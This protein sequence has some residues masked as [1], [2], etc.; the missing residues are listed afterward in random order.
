MIYIIIISA[1]VVVLLAV[2]YAAVFVPHILEAE[3]VGTNFRIKFWFVT[4]SGGK[5]KK[6]K[7]KAE[8]KSAPKDY[9]R[10]PTVEYLKRIAVNIRLH[11]D[12]IRLLLKDF[13]GLAALVRLDISAGYGTGD[14]AV[15]AIC[16]GI[17]WQIITP[18][19]E[20]VIKKYD[21][22]GKINAAITPYFD[23]KKFE[24]RIFLQTKIRLLDWIKL[25]CRGKKLIKLIDT[26]GKNNG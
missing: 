22:E 15:T 16:Y 10:I 2:V 5:K 19:H 1:V 8:K 21:A 9:V 14:A 11:G 25:Y 4:V 23:E 13:F 24:Y 20:F 6:K 26:E 18:L 3:A 12:D 7:K 17:A